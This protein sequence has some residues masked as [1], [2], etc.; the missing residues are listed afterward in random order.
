M[1]TYCLL[2]YVLVITTYLEVSGY[3]RSMWSKSTS[4]SMPQK[5][6]LRLNCAFVF[7]LERNCTMNVTQLSKSLR[8]TG[9]MREYVSGGR[10]PC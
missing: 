10:A 5:S 2:V 4:S 7:Q 1:A 8:V 3:H 6:E 9:A